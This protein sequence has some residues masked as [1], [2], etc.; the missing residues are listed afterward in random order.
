MNIGQN[1]YDWFSSNAQSLVL[2][3]III[4]GILLAIKRE[5]TKMIGFLVVSLIS[6]GLVFNTA[7]VKDLLLQIFRT[8]TGT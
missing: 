7:G 8:F 4:I 3:G 6:V 5:F 1:I 2:V